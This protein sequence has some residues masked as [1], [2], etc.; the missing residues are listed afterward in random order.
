MLSL[1]LLAIE[2]GSDLRLACHVC[3][4]LRRMHEND[5]DITAVAAP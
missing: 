4:N 5:F 3:N 2:I 1:F